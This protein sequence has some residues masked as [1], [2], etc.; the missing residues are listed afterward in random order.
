MNSTQF[1]PNEDFNRY[2]RDFDRDK[3]L[4]ENEGVDII[5]HPSKEEMYLKSHRTFIITKNLANKL[6]GVSRPTHFRGVTT[7]VAK[8]FNSIKPHAAIFGQ[9][10]A[11]QS[12]II[13]RMTNDLNMD[14]KIVIAPIIREND[15]L[16]LSSR[17]EYLDK[18]ERVQAVVLYQS[19]QRAEELIKSGER[20][21]KNLEKIMLEKINSVSI[22]RL[23]YLSF[24]DFENLEQVKV[25]KD[26]TLIALA[27]YF[28][29]T[30]L[31]DNT[32]IRL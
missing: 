24:V 25:I 28:G 11:Q 20:N 26:N 7:V 10:D 12:L 2:P 27:V 21:V 15:G 4:C 22:A 13:M 1:G 16:A 8:L 23:D 9:K 5:F 14:V 29:K 3:E 31:I 6:C 32:I 19:L 17:N 30:R 18:T